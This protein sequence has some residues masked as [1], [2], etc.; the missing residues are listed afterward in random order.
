MPQRPEFPGDAPDGGHGAGDVNGGPGASTASASAWSGGES[1]DEFPSPPGIG[2]IPLSCHDGCACP[3]HEMTAGKGHFP[4]GGSPD[5][6]NNH[7]MAQQ[8]SGA[9][10]ATRVI[11]NRGGELGALINAVT[12]NDAAVERGLRRLRLRMAEHPLGKARRQLD[13]LEDVYASIPPD[14]R[15]KTHPW[16]QGFVWATIAAIAA[17]ESW[18]LYRVGLESLQIRE[19]DPSGYLGWLLGP[20]LAFFV[21]GLG[22]SLSEWTTRLRATR[23]LRDDPP[24]PDTP[25][26]FHRRAFR[27]V[28]VFVTRRPGLVPTV[29]GL[30]GLIWLGY[31]FL[32]LAYYRAEGVL[33][34][35]S[36]AV[37]ALLG[38]F[39]VGAVFLEALVHNPYAA[40]HKRLRRVRDQA[41]REYETHCD[42]V[43]EW[44][45][46]HRQAHSTLRSRRDEL[47]GIARIEVVRAWQSA[48]LPARFRHG[49]ASPRAPVT[50]KPTDTLPEEP[51]P[52]RLSPR[53][54]ERYFRVFENVDTPVPDLA[55]LWEAGRV[56]E[57]YSPDRHAAELDSLL[58]E[59]G[60]STT[61]SGGDGATASTEGADR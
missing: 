39:A 13:D 18:F 25:E 58:R 46:R 21:Y 24:D 35:P 26:L 51:F 31:V 27:A 59:I 37:M 57:R 7:E 3:Q 20:V 53:D 19:G 4:D 16:L 14:E 52:E 44:I 40:A 1:P 29:L 45:S 30:G 55:G 41:I 34:V 47:L 33:Q 8:F 54:V 23:H 36:F 48:N 60:D 11:V 5:A 2:F 50:A 49:M 22:R 43:Q 56:L 38:T 17:L 28:T 15:A 42:D 6:V 10:N 61:P 32:M 9:I 12:E